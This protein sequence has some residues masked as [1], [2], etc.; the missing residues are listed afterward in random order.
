MDIA[1]HMLF[2]FL[3]LFFFWGDYLLDF[4]PC[5]SLIIKKTTWRGGMGG[6]EVQEGRGMWLPWLTHADVRQKPTQHCK[7][8]TLQLKISKF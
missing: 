7:A 1:I 5:Y 3:V 6:M 8:I 2:C 4:F